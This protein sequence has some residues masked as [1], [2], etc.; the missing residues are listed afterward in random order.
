[1]IK[2]IL[3][4]IILGTIIYIG[5][6][7]Y[8]IWT[9][10]GQVDPPNTDAAIVLGAAA[11]YDDPSPVLKERI[12]H[13]IELYTNGRVDQIIFTGGKGEGAK[14]AESEVSKSYAVEQGVPK[15]DIYIETKSKFTVENLQYAKALGDQEGFE[16]Y[17]IVSDPLHMKR[18]MAMAKDIGFNAYASPTQTS[19]YQ[20]L[21]TKI[22]FF[23]KQWA[24]YLAYQ[25]STLFGLFNPAG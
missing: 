1:M 19:A 2:K 7:G 11:W 8:S 12:N 15:S 16:S 14:Y 20:S 17:T 23:V 6:T 22:P 4:F 10:E 18:A 13:G 24:Y 9:F 25:A 3:Q 21:E 5:Y